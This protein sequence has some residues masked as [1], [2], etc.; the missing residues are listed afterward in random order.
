MTRKTISIAVAGL[1]FAVLVWAGITFRGLIERRVRLWQFARAEG[2][3]REALA[4]R[5][6]S[7]G[8]VEV[9]EAWYL[10][11]LESEEASARALAIRRLGAMRS[12]RAVPELIARLRSQDSFT[13][14]EA[15]YEAL[16]QIG[17]PAVTGLVAEVGGSGRWRAPSLF[18]AGAALS[19]VRSGHAG[20]GPDRGAAFPRRLREPA[21]R[22]DWALAG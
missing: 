14:D 5:L 13:A 10:E 8:A 1:A 3:A 17:A 20:G 12:A 16:A 22:G 4:E 9:V 6:L 18:V 7:L 19:K 2:E 11:L 21:G 15:L